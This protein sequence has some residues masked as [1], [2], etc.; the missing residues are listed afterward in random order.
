MTEKEGFSS[1]FV[2]GT[3]ALKM[4]KFNL[5]S[6]LP[7]FI[8]V[9]TFV[10]V[11]AIF[12]KPALE[13][14]VLQ[15]SDNVQWKA[16]YEDQRKYQEKNGELPLWSNGM[17]SGMPGYQIAMYAPN[18][19]SLGYVYNLMTLGLPKPLYFFVLAALCFY[20]LTQ[21]LRI[22]PYLGILGG[23]SYAFATYNPIIISVGH[24]T[25]MLAIAYIPALIGSIILLFEKKYLLGTAL[26]ALFSGL[27]ISVNHP[28]I[29]YYTFIVIL[30]MSVGYL[31]NWLKQKEYLHIFKVVGLAAIATVLGIAS[32]AVLLGTTYEYSKESIRGGTVLAD[33]KSNFSKS[34]LN[35]DYAL[36]YSVFKSEPLVMMFPRLYGGSTGNLE[37]AEDKSKAIEALQQMPQEL[38]QQLQGFL[39]FYW[40]GITSGTAGPPYSGAIICFLAILGLSFIP[41][42]HKW[43]MIAATLIA[44]M[45]SWGHYFEGFN[46]FL[47][48]N[49]PLFNKFRAPSMIL[50]IP[51]FIFALSAVIAAQELLFNQKATDAIKKYK[52]GLLVV[53]G[54]FALALM[55][56]LTSDF[57]TENDENLIKQVSEIS[58]PQQRNAI[59]PSARAFVEA[60]QEDRKGL[61]WGDIM[62]SFLFILI[63]AGSIWL[64]FQKK[65]S[66]IWALVIVAAASL[67]D[68]FGID[69]KYLNENNYQEEE[70][71]AQT[72]TPAPHNL[73][74]AKDTSYYRVFDI[75]NGVSA[76]FNGYAT[77]SVFHQ[78]IGGYHAAKLSIY[79]DLIEKQLYNFP[80]CA[81]TLDMLNTKY[82]IF[83]DPQSNQI[84]YQVNPTAAGPCWYVD[85]VS[86]ITEP[87]KLIKTLDSLNIRNTALIEAKIDAPIAKNMQG[88]SIW[89]I[90]NDH[91][92][93]YYSSL[94]TDNRFAVFSE[95]YYSKGWKAYIDGKESNIYK[96]NYVLRGL[97]IPAGKHEIKF[98]FKPDSFSKGVPIAITASGIIWLLLIGNLFVLL[99]SNKNTP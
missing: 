52:K 8:A 6:L 78:N 46:V 29:V 5:K 44:F 55:L 61:F 80:N 16:M 99:K 71:Y 45:I 63:A 70:E 47:L 33:G 13:G 2:S 81:P 48:E 54:V 23:L 28:Q 90:K 97:I 22:N 89:L 21:I 56:Y 69:S 67:I 85:S 93:I 31:V 68:I 37:V 64:Y 17:F 73:E 98:E 41:N 79:Q 83:K 75:T 65:L 10:V 92:R 25:K 91:D 50:V 38:A 27:I 53:A 18:P 82:I 34:G 84:Q 86:V 15:Q 20:I 32:N 51:T 57:K 12:C 60:L 3:K 39:Q 74:I 96:T 9:V 40:G 7:H 87:A 26:T 35:K 66:A 43:W 42:K 36:S 77:P 49:L 94:S 59:L 88:D 95:V 72:F 76:A 4:K 30:C 14:K 58:D 1:T 24:D 19:F 62:R 11:A